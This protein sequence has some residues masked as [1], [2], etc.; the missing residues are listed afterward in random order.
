MKN[1]SLFHPEKYDNNGYEKIADGVW[2]LDGEYFVSF[3]FEQE[4]EYNE[5]NVPGQISQYPLE[6][7]TDKFGLYVSDF[8]DDLNANDSS[9]RYV[10]LASDD[11][12]DVI[13]ASAIAGKHI[14]NKTVVNNGR[15]CSQLVIE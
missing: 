1:I 8:Y 12:S 15:E 6:D 9:V 7:I 3:K 4:S 13:K 11:E 2:G 14:Y 5:D 10:E